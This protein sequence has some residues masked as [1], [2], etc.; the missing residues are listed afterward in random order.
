MAKPI[1]IHFKLGEYTAGKFDNTTTSQHLI[2][3]E[4]TIYLATNDLF[5]AHLIYDDG[6]NF[7][8]I[9]PRMLGYHNGGVGIDLTEAP[10]NATFIQGSDRNKMS[11]VASANG[12]YYSTGTNVTPK[13]GILPVGCGGTGATAFTKYGVIYGNDTGSLQ[14]TD[15]GIE[16][17]ILAG[18]GTIEA[19]AAPRFLA[20]RISW[21]EVTDNKLLFN[22]GIGNVTYSAQIPNASAENS[23]IVTI[24]P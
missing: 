7:L 1:P 5:S 13:F 6:T 18:S 4:G 16:G 20:P 19:L 21:N 8:D 14:A 22:L 9:I 11:W 10:S 24:G 15:P 3:K 17:T 12:A 2:H 23:G